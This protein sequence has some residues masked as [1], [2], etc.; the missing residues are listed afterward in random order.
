MGEQLQIQMSC[1]ELHIKL[2][3]PEE[4]RECG[5]MLNAYDNAFTA[6]QPK[7]LCCGPC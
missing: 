6:S 5:S 3:G 4:K 1:I 7:L 2:V